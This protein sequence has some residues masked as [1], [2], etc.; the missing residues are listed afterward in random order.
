MV[1]SGLAGAVLGWAWLTQERGGWFFPGLALLAAG[2][3]LVHRKERNELLA[4]ARNI[5]LAAS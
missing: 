1:V 3:A 4:L 5:G 2:S